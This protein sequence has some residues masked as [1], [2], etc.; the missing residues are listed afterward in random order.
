M[1]FHNAHSVLHYAAHADDIEDRAV[2]FPVFSA[3][4][5]VLRLGETP[6]SCKNERIYEQTVVRDFV[7]ETEQHGRPAHICRALAAQAAIFAKYGMLERALETHQKMHDIYICGSYSEEISMAYG[8]DRAVQCYGL[9]TI[10]YDLLGK[11]E[12]LESQTDYILNNLIP[13]LD[14]KN[15]HNTFMLLFPVMCT[16]K[17]RGMALE[18]RHII[19]SNI[20]EKFEEYFGEGKSTFLRSMYKPTEVLYGLA[21]GLWQDG[22]T[23]IW[24]EIVDWALQSETGKL[25]A[26]MESATQGIGRDGK[27]TVAEICLLLAKSSRMDDD[28]R[29]LCL[30]EK[31]MMLVEESLSYLLTFKSRGSQLSLYAY[32]QSVE[33][34]T[35]LIILADTMQ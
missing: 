6:L 4:L 32:A 21:G 35:S 17:R 30:I 24:D 16:M 28:I 20:I 11:K 33:V 23:E 13:R 29:R 15:V 31:G 2:S 1:A 9:A 19:I 18:A 8:S 22:N 27:G 10:W 34:H 12:E 14:L 26:H 25:S 3:L 7:R 5:L